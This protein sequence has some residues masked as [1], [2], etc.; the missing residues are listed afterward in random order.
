MEDFS[1]FGFLLNILNSRF[2]VSVGTY[3][4][5]SENIFPVY[6][7]RFMNVFIYLHFSFL[8]LMFYPSFFNF[9]FFPEVG[10]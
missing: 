6:W 4:I 2:L 3:L 8:C 5:L 10:V 7:S 9:W 1:D